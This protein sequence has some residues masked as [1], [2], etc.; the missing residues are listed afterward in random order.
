VDVPLFERHFVQASRVALSFALETREAA[1]RPL[2]FE[3]LEEVL[4]GAVEID[5]RLLANMRRD[6][7][8]PRALAPF[9]LDEARFELSQLRPL[10][11]QRVCPLRLIQAPVED[12]TGRADALR[13]QHRLHPVRV[14]LES[15]RLPHQL[16]LLSRTHVHTIDNS[17][18]GAAGLFP[19]GERRGAKARFRPWQRDRRIARRSFACSAF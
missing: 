11:A 16:L 5:Q 3:P 6:L 14:E 18:A 19:D 1:P 4:E 7:I 2:T 17:A 9:Q 13:Q 10:S 8:Q 15:E 12:V